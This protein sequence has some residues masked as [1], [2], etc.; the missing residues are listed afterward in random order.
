VQAISLQQPAD[1]NQWH[2][3]MDGCA[4]GALPPQCLPPQS[5]GPIPEDRFAEIDDQSV[6]RGDFLGKA[7]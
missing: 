4:N 3:E 1:L 7:V 2:F 5:H 6:V